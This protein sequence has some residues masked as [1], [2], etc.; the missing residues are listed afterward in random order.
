MKS[1]SSIK[2]QNVKQF[3]ALNGTYNICFKKRYADAGF[4]LLMQGGR[5]HCLPDDNYIVSARHRELLDAAR[6]PYE[7]APQ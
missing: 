6:I 7:V 2:K 5:F 4:A 3:A 1:N